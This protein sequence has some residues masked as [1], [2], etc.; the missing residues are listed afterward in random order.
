M[1]LIAFSWKNHPAY[2]LVLVGN[3]DEFFER[4]SAP[5]QQWEAG[6]YAGKDLKAGGTWLGIHPNGRFA[7]LTNYRDLKNP[8]KDPK[9]R[10]DLVKNFLEGDIHPYEYLQAIN[11]EKDRYEGFNLLV[12]DGD[13]MFY[14]SNYK[15]GIE[16]I[17]PGV[18]G[19]SNALLDTPWTKLN[20]AKDKFSEIIENGES[21]LEAYFDAIHSRKQDPEELLPDTG[22]TLYQEKHL[23]AQF[24][25]IDDYYGTVNSTVLRWEYS[26][27]VEILERSFEQLKDLYFDTQIDFQIEK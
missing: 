18:Y 26:G 1:C 15:E 2:K 25:R 21:R 23:S 16:E 3:R 7:T 27:K 5:I 19:L 8:K 13:S 4:P 22:A 6:F 11:K 20:R 12:S 24:I 9:T 17:S 14:L 10:G